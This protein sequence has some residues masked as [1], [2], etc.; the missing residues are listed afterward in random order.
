MSTEDQESAAPAKKPA[1]K[2]VARVRVKKP[3]TLLG[4]F[5]RARGVVVEG[6]PLADAEYKQKQ[7][8]LEILEVSDA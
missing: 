6:V 1:K 2:Q 4:N 5:Y 8:A 7:G 3:K